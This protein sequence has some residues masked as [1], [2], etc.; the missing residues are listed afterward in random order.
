[1][2]NYELLTIEEVSRLLRVSERTV[3]DWAQKGEI[4]CGKFGTSWR[5]RKT[6][7]ME[8][9]DNRLPGSKKKPVVRLPIPMASILSRERIA[10][11]E[12]A[13]KEAAFTHLVDLMA[14]SPQIHDRNQLLEQ[15]FQREELMSTGIGMGIG[16][17]HVRLNTVDDLVVAFGICREPVVDYTSLDDEPIR[18]IAMIAVNSDQHA[19]HIR[20]LSAV[21]G[22]LKDKA[23]RMA[24]LAAE[25]PDQ[26]YDLLTQGERQ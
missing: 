15:L 22:I 9:I 25:S 16:V 13:Y 20:A 11:I 5:F 21:T 4:P 18:L 19:K 2:K 14:T 1:M 24:V 23:I 10:F 6:E 3:Y 7:I 17:P 12:A 8:W 26:A